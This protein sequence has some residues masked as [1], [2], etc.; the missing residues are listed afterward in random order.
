[1]THCVSLDCV[2][3]LSNGLSAASKRQFIA[4]DALTR[5]HKDRARLVQSHIH[6]GHD[7]VVTVSRD[8]LLRDGNECRFGFV[9][10]IY[11]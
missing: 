5:A 1:M 10:V 3:I 11:C 9:A 7:T 2:Q 4:I 6:L 8:R